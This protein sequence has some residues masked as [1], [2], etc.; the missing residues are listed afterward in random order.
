M[1]IQAFT[2]GPLSSVGTAYSSG[3]VL[4]ASIMTFLVNLALGSF[5]DITLPSLIIPFPGIL[6][7]AYRAVIWGILFSPAHFEAYLVP[8]HLILFLEGGPGI[9]PGHARRL[10]PGEIFPATGVRWGR[11]QKAGV[12]P[13]I[14]G[15]HAAL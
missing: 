11:R 7:G 14:Q 3:Q 6:T 2:I 1:V 15:R 8:R 5:M 13:G 4:D 9:C 10:Y 12:R